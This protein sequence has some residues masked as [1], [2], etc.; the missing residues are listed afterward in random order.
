MLTKLKFQILPDNQTRLGLLCGPINSTLK[1]I[2]DALNIKISNRGNNF[3]LKG[4]KINIDAGKVVIENLYNKSID[5]DIISPEEVHLYLREATNFKNNSSS[6]LVNG[7]TTITIKT[8]KSIVIPKGKN[9]NKYIETIEKKDL[10][11][12][13]G[14]AGT[15]KTYLAVASAIQGLV[16]GQVERILLVRPAVEAGEKLGFLP[17]D[18]NEKIN[19]YLRPLYDALFEM[20]GYK[21]TSN[22]IEKKVIE[23][24]PLA[25]MRG[26]TLNNAFIILDEGQ[27]TTQKQMKMFLTRF[28]FGSTVVVTG[29][30]TQIDLP[31]DTISGL[32][33]CLDVLKGIKNVG[34][35]NFSNSD[36]VRH[37]LV[38]EIVEAY[39]KYK[40]SV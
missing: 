4:D 12:G 40:T 17:G 35:I 18:L 38:Q 7:S 2:E 10:T 16:T 9:Q 39:E 37:G 13:I 32:M 23:V 20:L 29:D 15:G 28:G 25:F 19:P 34:F 3:K 36:V 26:R 33:H 22:F 21:E 8:P 11:F 30:I 31:H 27:N 24:V 6:S 14:P 5:G 1:Q